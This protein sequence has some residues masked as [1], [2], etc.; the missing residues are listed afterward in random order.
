MQKHDKPCIVEITAFI[1]CW[2]K[3][4]ITKVYDNI[5]N[6][7]DDINGFLRNETGFHTI[8]GSLKAAVVEGM[9]L[10]ISQQNTIYNGRAIA[11]RFYLTQ[12]ENE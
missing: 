12:P 2:D 4:T 7:V 5:D 3:Q 9:Y 1:D 10:R 6:A 11:F 8:R